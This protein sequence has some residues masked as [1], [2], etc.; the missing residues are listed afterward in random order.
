LQFRDAMAGDGQFGAV[1]GQLDLRLRTPVE[2]GVSFDVG[3]E[4]VHAPPH[5]HQLAAAQP[6]FEPDGL[7]HCGGLREE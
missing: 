6:D 5:P 7:Q 2:P 1:F 4:L 3:F